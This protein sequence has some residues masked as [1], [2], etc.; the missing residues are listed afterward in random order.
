M[1]ATSPLEPHVFDIKRNGFAKI[2]A[3][4]RMELTGPLSENS[5]KNSI[6]NAD[7]MIRFGR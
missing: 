1:N 5:A 3:D 4:T 7:A 2:P 6:A